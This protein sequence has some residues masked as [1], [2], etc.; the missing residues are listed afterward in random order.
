M[1]N[2]VNVKNDAGAQPR[3]T[4]VLC[5]QRMAWDQ[6]YSDDS[7]VQYSVCYDAVDTHYDGC[8]KIQIKAVN[9]VDLPITQLDWLISCLYKIREEVGPNVELTGSKG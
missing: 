3:F 8:A 5:P 6:K 1:E 2:I 4:A 7:G 9:S